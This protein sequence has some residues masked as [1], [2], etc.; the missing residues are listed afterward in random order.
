MKSVDEIGK[1]VTY[2]WQ[3][4]NLQRAKWIDRFNKEVAK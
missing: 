1:F 4:I 3:K 2:D